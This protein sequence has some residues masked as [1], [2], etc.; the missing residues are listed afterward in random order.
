M[1]LGMEEYLKKK[2]FE[3]G[4]IILLLSSEPL[5]MKAGKSEVLGQPSLPGALSQAFGTKI[6]YLKK[7][8]K[9]KNF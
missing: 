4:H 8:Y 6:L 2:A 5:D 9:L 3:V 7:W 1:N